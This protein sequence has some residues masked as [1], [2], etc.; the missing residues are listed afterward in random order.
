MS[1]YIGIIILVINVNFAFAQNVKHQILLLGN[2]ANEDLNHPIFDHL[3]HQ[4][5]EGMSIALLGDLTDQNGISKSIGDSNLKRLEWYKQLSNQSKQP[6]YYIAGDR[7]WDNN[8]ENG[9]KK[10]KNLKK[11]IEKQYNRTL[12]YTPASECPDPQVV[13]LNEQL[14]M[15]M[16]NSQWFLHPNDKN[17]SLDTDCKIGNEGDFFEELEDIIDDYE[18]KNILLIA[19]HPI[20]TG[21]KYWS[22]WLKYLIPI[23]AMMQDS[24][25]NYVG[26]PKDI[27]NPR[28]KNYAR[29]MKHLLRGKESIIYVSAHEHAN[30]V[31]RSKKNVFINSSASFETFNT[32]TGSKNVFIKSKPGYHIL[33]Y[34]DDG[35][36]DLNTHYFTKGKIKTISTNLLHAKCDQ[37]NNQYNYAID[38]CNAYGSEKDNQY[39]SFPTDH[40]DS[41][42]IAGPKYGGNI[43]KNLIMGTQ[44]RAEW[45][46][47]IKV[48]FVDL[49]TINGGLVPY[50]KGGGLQTVSLKFKGKEGRKY[51]FRPVNKK[52][53]KSLPEDLKLTLY[54]DIVKELIV[55]QHPYGGLVASKLM[56]EL[57]IIHAEPT[58]YLM[59]DDAILG[60]YRAEFKGQL[61][62]VEEKIKGKSKSKKRKGYAGADKIIQSN[63]LFHSLYK[64]SRNRMDKSS[65]A[66]ARV[67]DMWIGDWDRH[68]D[69][70]KWAGYKQ[71]KGMRYYAVPKDRDHVFSQWT[72]VVPGI[73]DK[74][75]MNAEHFDYEFG[76]IT[77]LNFKAR[78][79]DR[80]LGT[81][82]ELEDWLSAVDKLVETMTDEKIEKA[83]EIWPRA[84]FDIQGQIIINK[85]K[86]RR[87]LLAQAVSDL[88]AMLADEVE[89]VGSNKKEIFTI[90]R[91]EN[92]DVYISFARAKKPSKVLYERLFKYGET[93]R[94][95]I[96]GLSGKDKF[97]VSGN[98]NKSIKVRIIGG[99]N[100][101]TI[102][103]TSTGKGSKKFRVFDNTEK[104]EIQST[105]LSKAKQTA[106]P[107][108]YENQRFNYGM[109]LPLPDIS[110]SSGNGLGLGVSIMKTTI[111][112]GKPDF[113]NK[114]NIGYLYYPELG[115]HKMQFG[116][117]RRHMYK[118]WDFKI[119]QTVANFYD[120]F[121]YFY[122]FGSK[123]TRFREYDDNEI[124]AL[125]FFTLRTRAGLSKDLVGRSHLAVFFNYEYNNVKAKNTTNIFSEYQSLIGWN[126]LHIAGLE[127]D[128]VLDFRDNAIFP[129]NGSMLTVN[130]KVNMNL[131]EGLGVFNMNNW[132]FSHYKSVKWWKE[133]IF[134]GRIGGGYVFG[135]VPFYHKTTLGS[136]NSLR[137]YTRN[138]FLDDFSLFYNLEIKFHL[139]TWYT[140]IVPLRFGF[141]NFYES[142]IVWGD[143]SF[144]ANK[145]N[146]NYGI[147]FYIAPVKD[148][149]S[150]NLYIAESNDKGLYFNYR[151]NWTF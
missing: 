129:K 85:L 30:Y 150:L 91:K 83:F 75:V 22:N 61:G 4:V 146:D 144:K 81:E 33:N 42:A 96:Y 50:A 18:G 51:V 104:D 114:Y 118:D 8:G 103:D 7:D 25:S 100:K 57:D 133:I 19:H 97:L 105:H 151:L 36:I 27:S 141:F 17:S 37:L 98:A 2:T 136:N 12:D 1:R 89:I 66:L 110:N 116:F 87:N 99:R 68:Q 119:R 38:P 93:T 86:S 9:N 135:D 95:N 77:H 54:K 73:A 47:P 142:G 13:E 109:M 53:E 143:Q 92:G 125:E 71:D 140:P 45:T 94:I 55:S 34:N 113:K 78:W 79:I 39:T 16:I 72:G 147:G 3:N 52:P 111:G 31:F 63:Q 84:I 69:N 5:T 60:K 120:K 74:V 29:K 124:F 115:A 134:S 20:Y 67:F 123:T 137:G 62:T 107:V 101:D 26:G 148:T 128:F 32:I 10:N 49:S 132:T 56:K 90:V 6:P 15:V 149:Y 48:P 41:I 59:P 65:Y 106:Y 112:F 43:L 23:Y 139:G 64:N 102:E 88:Y 35:S 70:W 11:F 138:R 58:L 131:T 46:Q 82:L 80:Q 126:K 21:G 127:L 122:G 130:S 121:P 108:D 24:Y 28:Y 117:T 145:W 44:Y 40:K 14:V 76:N